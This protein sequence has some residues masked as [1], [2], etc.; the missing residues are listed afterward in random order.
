M[1]KQYDEDEGGN[2]VSGSPDPRRMPPLKLPAGLDTCVSHITIGAAAEIACTEIIQANQLQWDL[3]L[4]GPMSM[5][6]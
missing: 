5:S 4:S 2:A 6:Q 1:K 3:M